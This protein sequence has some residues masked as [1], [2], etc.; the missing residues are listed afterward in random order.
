MSLFTNSDIFVGSGL[1][2]IIVCIFLLLCMPCNFGRM[3]TIVN[4]MFLYA[5][6]FVFI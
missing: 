2:L 4:F 6:Y 5:W 1:P 3:L